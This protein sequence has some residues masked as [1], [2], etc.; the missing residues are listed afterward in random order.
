MGLWTG[1]EAVKFALKL[2][3]V[4]LPNPTTKL[5]IIAQWTPKWLHVSSVLEIVGKLSSNSLELC[6]K[7]P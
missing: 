4:A 2:F 5:E 6:Q 7:D 3:V 1:Q